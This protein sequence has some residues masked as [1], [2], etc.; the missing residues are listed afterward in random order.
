MMTGGGWRE[1]GDPAKHVT[2]SAWLIAGTGVLTQT[3]PGIAEHVYRASSTAATEQK[4]FLVMVGVGHSFGPLATG[5]SVTS[6][7]EPLTYH[8]CKMDPSSALHPIP[9]LLLP[10]RKT[11][12]S[13]S[14]FK[15]PG[16]VSVAQMALWVHEAL[17]DSQSQA[18]PCPQS[19]GRLHDARPGQHTSPPASPV[20]PCPWGR[21]RL[22]GWIHASTDT[23]ASKT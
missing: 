12:W 8:V 18:C 15:Q 14:A 10:C 23:L 20:S 1:L 17:G 7:G 13:V 16:K 3:L 2:A 21:S 19:V 22:V 11:W 9:C 6:K 5:S 4:P